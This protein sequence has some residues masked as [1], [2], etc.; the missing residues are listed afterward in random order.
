MYYSSGLE[1]WENIIVLLNLERPDLSFV[2]DQSTHIEQTDM[3][4]IRGYSGES[5]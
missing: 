3:F 2:V 1:S 5:E 4:L